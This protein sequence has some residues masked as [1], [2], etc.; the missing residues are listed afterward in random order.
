MKSVIYKEII[1]SFDVI[2][3]KGN[4]INKHLGL[5]Q[6]M[7]E[8]NDGGKSYTMQSFPCDPNYEFISE[9]EKVFDENFNIIKDL[10]ENIRI[11]HLFQK[12]NIYVNDFEAENSYIH[13]INLQDN[14]SKTSLNY[15]SKDKIINKHDLNL[16]IEKLIQII[17][18]TN[19]LQSGNWEYSKIV[20]DKEASGVIIAMIIGYFFEG[21]RV[22]SNTSYFFN[23]IEKF[24]TN[25][26][27][28][29]YDELRCDL[30]VYFEYDQEG[31]KAN[32][33]VFLIK[34]GK[35][36][37][38]LTDI[39]SSA[40]LNVENNGRSRS[41]DY[42]TIPSPRITNI[43]VEKGNIN[44]NQ[45]ISTIERGIYCTGVSGVALDAASGII[46]VNCLLGYQIKDKKLNSDIIIKEPGFSFEVFDFLKNIIHTC[47]ESGVGYRIM[48]KGRPMQ[49]TLVGFS[50]PEI[51]LEGSRL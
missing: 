33:K 22:A 9:I 7:R 6:G 26:S 19:Y 27:I 4:V 32:K 30:P 47:D 3:E 34:D 16:K 39:N 12:R 5:W 40:K 24:S 38:C 36:G 37:S 25:V 35:I 18:H 43:V 50:S 23:H 49:N 10:N 44:F 15:Y 21:N 41:Q 45:M 42:R 46:H 31:I 51:C 28:N 2:C 17:D 14:I 20:F 13:L 48:G 11:T 8:T 29:I 1:K